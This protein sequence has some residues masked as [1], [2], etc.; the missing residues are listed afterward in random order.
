MLGEFI[1]L[2]DMDMMNE[3]PEGEGLV[4]EWS[5]G[6]GIETDFTGLEKGS[7]TPFMICLKYIKNKLIFS[8]K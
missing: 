7:E 3:T 1:Q 5:R 8:E 2:Y 6:F 4:F